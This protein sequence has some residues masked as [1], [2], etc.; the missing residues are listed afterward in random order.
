[1]Y[2]CAKVAGEIPRDM[3]PSEHYEKLL[4][5]IAMRAS[6][7]DGWGYLVARAE[8]LW[9]QL[10]Q[11]YYKIYPGMV[12]QLRHVSLD[13]DNS[14]LQMPFPVFAVRISE[15]HQIDAAG[16]TGM[17]VKH[18]SLSSAELEQCRDTYERATLK[19]AKAAGF[20]GGLMLMF[21]T[22][23]RYVQR[24]GHPVSAGGLRLVRTYFLAGETLEAALS[25]SAEGWRDSK[26]KSIGLSTSAEESAES[27]VR[28]SR[29]AMAAALLG[30]SQHNLVLPDLTRKQQVKHDRAIAGGDVKRAA[31]LAKKATGWT[32]GR[33][34]K[35]PRF[36]KDSCDDEVG[37]GRKLTYSHVRSG[38][39]RMQAYGAGMS[40]RKL[41]YVAPIWVRPDLPVG[42]SRGYEIK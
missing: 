22:W 32:L 40:K 6:D 31:R 13:V 35:L 26:R 33:D 11:P 2:S 15:N 34:I 42:P 21:E 36:A 39:M 27:V 12:E 20:T 37:T 5:S 14:L 29:L 1:M 28:F 30:T 7:E 9:Y 38:H 23:S 17:L 10:G 18:V 25:R 24:P 19:E 3:P 41:I 16:A 8:S 4:A